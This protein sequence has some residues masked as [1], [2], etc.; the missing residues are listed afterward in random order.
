MF[1][2]NTSHFWQGATIWTALK[3]V[4]SREIS[5]LF[6]FRGKVH[7]VTSVSY[8]GSIKEFVLLRF[9]IQDA[10]CLESTKSFQWLSCYESF[11]SSMYISHNNSLLFFFLCSLCNVHGSVAVATRQLNGKGETLFW[12]KFKPTIGNLTGLRRFQVEEATRGWDLQAVPCSL[13]AC[14]SPSA[15]PSAREVHLYS[16]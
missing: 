2:F 10:S 7:H 15:L 12:C 14:T 11:F 6:Y 9:F 8:A 5:H 16:I 13:Y 4:P 3:W 1:F